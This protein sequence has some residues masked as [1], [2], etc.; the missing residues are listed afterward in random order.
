MNGNKQGKSLYQAGISTGKA[1]AAFSDTLSQI[2]NIGSERNY[3]T[4]SGELDTQKREEGIGFASEGIS[5]IGEEIER[6][7]EIRTGKKATQE[8][9]AK[10]AYEKRP[11]SKRMAETTSLDA[12]FNESDL[13][14][15]LRNIGITKTGPSTEYSQNTGKEGGDILSWDDYKETDKGKEFLKGFEAK[16][17]SKRSLWGEVM[18]DE[19]GLKDVA[20]NWGKLKESGF[21]GDTMYQFGDERIDESKLRRRGMFDEFTESK[22][23][24]DYIGDYT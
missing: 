8:K 24:F 19:W 12:D 15:E 22:N 4:A 7:K 20:S 21:W 1:S 18:G 16:K 11:E 5:L 10:E 9:F 13:P 17:V 3:I 2:V 6:S 23:M 14:P